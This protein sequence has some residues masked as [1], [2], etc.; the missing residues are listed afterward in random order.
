[1][2]YRRLGSSGLK[3]SAIGLGGNNFGV[4]LDAEG[5]RRVV[6]QALDAGINF[7]DTANVYGRGRSEEFIGK[8]LRGKRGHALIATKFGREMTPAPNG[9]GGSRKHIMDQVEASLRRLETDTIDLYQFHIHDPETPVEETLR[10]LDDLIRQ[11]KVRYIGCSQIKA[12][13]A[14]HAVWTSRAH[15]LH[16]F[17]SLQPHYSLLYRETEQE[18]IPFCL[19]HG[20]GVIPYF[21]LEGGFL[22]GKYR[23]GEAPPQGTRF[24]GQG[25]YQRLLTDSNFSILEKLTRFAEE[26]GRSVGELALAWLLANPVVSTVIPGATKPE[27][28]LANIRASDWRLLPQELVEIDE[29]TQSGKTGSQPH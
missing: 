27:Q 4:R 3:V 18:L 13:Q 10:A 6:D 14:C 25:N 20:L 24:A 5:T 29:I 21:P 15:G 11:G 22:T 9:G 23:P 19:A 2:E 16:A 1:M 17:V 28:V 8:A 12:W 7:I 26:R